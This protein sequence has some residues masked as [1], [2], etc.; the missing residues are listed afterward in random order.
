[1]PPRVAPPNHRH[2]QLAKGGKLHYQSNHCPRWLIMASVS[3]LWER[4]DLISGKILT[5][6]RIPSNQK[7]HTC[8]PTEGRET[9]TQSAS[10]PIHSKV[11]DS[12]RKKHEHHHHSNRNPKI[13]HVGQRRIVKPE[14]RVCQNRY[15]ARYAIHGKRNIN[16]MNI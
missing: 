9:R 5:I 11:C 1:M 12:W 10:K 2:P 13:T 14:H 8:R 15:I 4:S 3:M 6:S 7:S 16:T